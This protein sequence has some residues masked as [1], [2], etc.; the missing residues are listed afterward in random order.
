MVA[1]KQTAIVPK[2]RATNGRPYHEENENLA[3]RRSV[4][5]IH[6]CRDRR[7]RRSEK[8]KRLPQR[9]RRTP[10]PSC[11][12]AIHLLPLEKAHEEC[13]PSRLRTKFAFFSKPVGRRFVRTTQ[14]VGTGVLDGPK[15]HN[16][17]NENGGRGNPSPTTKKSKPRG[18]A[19][20][21]HTPKPSPV[22]EGGSRLSADG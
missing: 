20:C 18:A 22:G 7:P 3:A 15:P 8:N 5:A 17:R 13:T 19:V 11:L 6:H 10:H 12:T 9:K 14:F 2:R 1:R 16:N 4:R 21:S